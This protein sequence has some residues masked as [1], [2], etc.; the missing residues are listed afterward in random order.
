MNV[1]LVLRRSLLIATLLATVVAN[2]LAQAVEAVT[3][4]LRYQ[5]FVQKLETKQLTLDYPKAIRNLDANDT[6]TQ[7]TG[8]MTLSATGELAAIPFIVPLLD[9][10][11]RYVRVYAGLALEKLVSRHALK[12]RDDSQPMKIVIKPPSPEETDLRPLA[13][14]I[15][16][17]LRN[18]EDSGTASYAA[19]MIGYLNLQEFKPELK[20][21]LKSR[22]PANQNAAKHALEVMESASADPVPSR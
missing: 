18:P 12:R 14:V 4:E 5:L 6:E 20:Q 19:T 9:S 8:L 21:L 1:P 11:D 17:M 2:P 7:M 10:Q 16:K 15:A 13:W 22:H 3:P